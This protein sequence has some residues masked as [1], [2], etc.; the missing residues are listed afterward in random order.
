MTENLFSYGTLQ[1]KPVQLS[2]FGRELEGKPDYIVGYKL[3][4]IEITDPEVLATSGLTHHPILLYSGDKNDIIKGMVFKIT[5]QDLIQAD[6]YE[7][8]DYKRIR[9]PLKSGDE[10]WV[11]IDAK[12]S[13]ETNQ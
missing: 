4:Q 8:S 3:S 9:V 10:A 6:E 2:L 12:D 5:G 1:D 11:Y 13:K 7:T